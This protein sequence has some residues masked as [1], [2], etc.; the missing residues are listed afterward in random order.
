G[1]ASVSADVRTVTAGST[2]VPLSAGSFSAGGA[3]YN[4][5]S[6]ALSADAVLAAGSKAFTVTATDNALN[7]VSLK[8]SVSVDNTPPVATDVQTANPGTNGLAEQGDSVVLSFSEPIEPESILAG[9]NGSATPVVVRLIDNGL[10]GLPLGND[11][12][13][14]YNAA[15]SALLPLG[16]VDLGR[17][18]YVAGLLGG[19]VRFGASGTASTMTMSGNTVTVAFGTYNATAIVDPARTTAAGTGTMTWTPVATPFDRAANAM[20]TTTASESGAA[21][22]EF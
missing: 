18:D 8:G 13:Q 20:S 6:A 2:A 9:W 7:A 4:Y 21:D 14:V 15:N 12:L 22:R 3:S 17:S 5:R 11:A 1:I 10:L 16:T 19:N